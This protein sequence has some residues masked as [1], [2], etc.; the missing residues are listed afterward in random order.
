[1]PSAKYSETTKL[2]TT[3]S[4]RLNPSLFPLPTSAL[5]ET[6]ASYAYMDFVWDGIASI[7]SYREVQGALHRLAYPQILRK[8]VSLPTMDRCFASP[9][10][11]S[12]L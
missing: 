11:Q 9:P 10:C 12:S 6:D 4:D 8:Y 7:F 5:S 3:F 2:D 1:M